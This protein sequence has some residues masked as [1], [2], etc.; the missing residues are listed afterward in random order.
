MKISTIIVNYN[1]DNNLVRKGVKYLLI[2]N[3]FRGYI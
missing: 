3:K 2:I 1:V